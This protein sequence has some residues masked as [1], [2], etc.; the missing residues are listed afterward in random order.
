MPFWLD[1][2]KR[3]PSVAPESPRL[4]VPIVAQPS[5]LASAQIDAT[6]LPEIT[7][8]VYVIMNNRERYRAVGEPFSVPWWVIGA[9]HYRESSFDF[10]RW[11]AN[12]DPLSQP[13]TNTP[14]GLGPVKSWEEGARLSISAA[15]WNKR[16]SWDLSSALTHLEAYNG[17][18]Y[19]YHNL[20]SPYVWAGTNL[21]TKGKFS[22]DGKYDPE[23]V[24][25]QV[26]CAAIALI[27]K[28]KG[29][30]I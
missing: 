5:L 6:R 12:G 16:M 7:K 29:I 4:L 28:A 8:V 26:G 19:V 9:L 10:N 23:L 30:E 20:C 24:D 1:Y 11:L 22:A 21:Y 25:K 17:L 2:F 18:G 15:L 14:K 13:T 3:A 27:L